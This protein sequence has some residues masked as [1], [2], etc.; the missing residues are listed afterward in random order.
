MKPKRYGLESG[1]TG[2]RDETV[3]GASNQEIDDD[4]SG[5]Q[6]RGRGVGQAD[7]RPRPERPLVIEQRHQVLVRS[8]GKITRLEAA[9]FERQAVRWSVRPGDCKWFVTH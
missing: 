6:D 3:E 7:E 5:R 1:P 4:V 8:E 2:A 9:E